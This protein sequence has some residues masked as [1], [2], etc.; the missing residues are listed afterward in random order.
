MRV[1]FQAVAP[2]TEPT[3]ESYATNQTKY[4]PFRH[5]RASNLLE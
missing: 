4:S 5:L 1:G 2:A 3:R